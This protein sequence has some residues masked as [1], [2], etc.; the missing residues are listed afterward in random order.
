MNRRILL[1]C[2]HGAPSPC[3][4]A[5]AVLFSLILGT[6]HAQYQPF[7]PTEATPV[8][9]VRRALPVDASPSPTPAAKRRDH[10]AAASPSPSAYP[11][12]GSNGPAEPVAPT[13]ASESAAATAETPASTTVRP[14][15]KT[16]PEAGDTTPPT[17]TADGA[18]DIRLAPQKGHQS[19]DEVQFNLANALYV[20]K[21]YVQAA[22]EY[23]RYLGQF[24]EGKQRQAAMWWLGESYRILKRLPAARSSYQNLTVAFHEGEFVG[25]ATFRLAT[26]D[27]DDKDYNTAL[28]LFRRS[29]ALA[30]GQD[31]RL[32]SRYSEA[33][34]LE[35]LGR[36]D[37][38]REV[39]DDIINTPGE[40][41]YRDAARLASAN[42]AVSE[43]RFNEAFKQYEGL[44]REAAKPEL[45]AESSLKAGILASDLDQK[46]TAL[47][48]FKR[49]TE[50][51]GAT[52][53]VR[54]DAMIAELHLLYDTNKYQQLIDVY[55]GLRPALP[56]ALGPEAMLLA[57]NAQR[58]LGHHKEARAAYDEL[59]TQFSRTPQAAEARYQRI[60]SLYAGDDPNFVKEADDYIALAADP[61]KADQ[62]RLMKADTLFKER[63]YVGAA[64]AYGTLDA[65]TSL[66]AKY[67][68]EAAYRLG[69]C[70]SQ[71]RKPEQTVTAFNR[72]LRLFPDHPL[73][74]KALVLRGAAYQQLHNYAS[75]LRDFT[76]VIQDHKDA[77]ER[78][79]ALAQKALILGA[80]NDSRGL[81]AAFHDLLKDYPN[82]DV[83]PLAH[84]SIA[85]AAFNDVKDYALARDEFDAAR[86]SSPKDYG[87]RCSL[88]VIFCE[89]Q[90]KDKAR[91]AADIAD[92][93]K[94]KPRRPCPR[95]SCAG[96]AAR[97]ST[98]R[99]TPP[100]RATW[101]RRSPRRATRSPK[102]GCNWRERASRKK[103]GTGRS[104]RRSI[105]CKPALP[106]PAR[107][108]WA[109][110]CRAMRRWRC[111]TSR[112]HRRPST[113]SSSCSPR[114]RL[115]RRRCCC[116]ASWISHRA[117]T[118]RRRSHT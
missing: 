13:V 83:A 52:A 85:N 21:N 41:P 113:R 22:A 108:R 45:Q 33:L 5:L 17:D 43:K 18:D 95:R 50:L 106:T 1:G 44:S 14:R 107:G 30:K 80:Q 32:Y 51:P 29:A 101:P 105:T 37:E 23:E 91:L 98:T 89:Y 115:T 28:G 66:P 24:P 116:A 72:F 118:N 2:S 71:A 70:Y 26:I 84:Y 58:Q 15:A 117:S 93:E 92:Y 86:K 16:D 12:P 96:W 102:P 42:L 61:V 64:L 81:I 94:T 100:P 8:P 7:D 47:S 49:A 79:G 67:R 27:Y 73:A 48:L 104:R 9:A 62:V 114:A 88:M 90:L 109:C 53:Q 36:R 65:T 59:I 103:N 55:P 34:C 31:V 54:A 4:M 25:P 87:A 74:P 56:D 60:I 10:R 77:K 11:A 39:Y 68:A 76:S 40:N 38:T 46:D 82:T 75:A 35:Q 111:G 57:A 20:R 112:T 110:W 99:I 97:S 63:D 3:G 6:A 69:F 19:P 78:E